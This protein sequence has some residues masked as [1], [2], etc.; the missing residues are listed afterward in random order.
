LEVALKIFLR[1]RGI[2]RSSRRC[3]SRYNLHFLHM[4]CICYYFPYIQRVIARKRFHNLIGSKCNL[5]SSES[6]GFRLSGR[7]AARWF[8][9]KRSH[10][11][12][13]LISHR[14]LGI[15]EVRPSDYILIT[16]T[17]LT[18]RETISRA[19]SLKQDFVIILFFTAQPC[20][21]EESSFQWLA[22]FGDLAF[23]IW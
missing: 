13:S 19:C 21:S 8:K 22:I 3:V 15:S 23:I 9:I 16:D 20:V 10:F 6:N 12:P 2:V 11:L 7:S 14:F 5:N 17:L 1:G 4:F 18:F